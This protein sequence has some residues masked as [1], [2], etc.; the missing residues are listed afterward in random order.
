MRADSGVALITVIGVLGLVTILVITGFMVSSQA[1]HESNLANAETQAFQAAN[2]GLDA[3]VARIQYQGFS[4]DDFPM[5]F[6]AS[7][8]QSGA[9]TVTVDKISNSEYMIVSRG[10]GRGGADETLRVRMYFIDLYGMNIS[11]GARLDA[12]ASNG[13][14]NGTTS[15]YGPLYTYGSL[16][17]ENLGNGS[18]GIKWGPLMV[19]GGNVVSSGDYINVGAVYYEPP[20]TVSVGCTPQPR[21]IPSVPDFVVPAVDDA[22]LQRALA[23]AQTESADNN[24]GD[25]AYRTAIN[26]EVSTKGD[27]AT[28]TSTRAPGAVSTYSGYPGAYKV[29]DNDGVINKSSGLT[30]NSSTTSF[31]TATDDFAWDASSKTLTCWG[32][33]FID[34]PFTTGASFPIKYVGNGII[35]ANGTISLLGDFVPLNGLAP[36]F[37]GNNGDIMYANQSFNPNQT[38][39]IV[40]PD[41]IICDSGGGNPGNDPT[42]PPSHA[43]AFYCV[44]PNG[45]DPNLGLIQM[46]TK[47][48]V[49]GSVIARGIDFIANNNQ[50]LRTSANLGQCVSGHMPGYNQMVQSF[51]TWSRQ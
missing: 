23:R 30:I 36:G 38:L 35:V 18:G 40:S 22:Y 44:N 27:T 45:N 19:K 50:H 26:T 6:P 7:A 29:I 20:H 43:G 15:I 8:T 17:S 10:E 16:D 42:T 21:M 34:G 32:A 39:G 49:V 2:A 28:Y 47:T 14:I 37:G 51:G 48:A 25:P 24:Q 5:T 31:G 12:N 46:G 9:A 3:A 13:K 1:L 41:K 11:F 4:E 33:V